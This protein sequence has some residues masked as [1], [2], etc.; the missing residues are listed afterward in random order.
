MEYGFYFFSLHEIYFLKVKYDVP[1]IFNQKY[2]K[3]NPINNVIPI[4]LSFIIIITI[5]GHDPPSRSGSYVKWNNACT[6]IQHTL[7]HIIYSA[8]VS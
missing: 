6:I 1:L 4:Y 8:P 5:I 2:K 3:Q 7:V